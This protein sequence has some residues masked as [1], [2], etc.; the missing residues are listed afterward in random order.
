MASLEE[1]QAQ[2]AALI[3]ALSSAKAVRH[4]DKS[5]ENRDIADIREALR[6]INE[7]IVAAG[8]GK[9]RRQIRVYT[10]RGL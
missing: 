6:A 9:R 7:E 3:K 2:K 5:V 4:G 10:D 8:G 1:L